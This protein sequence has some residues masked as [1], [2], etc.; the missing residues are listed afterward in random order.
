M[1]ARCALGARARKKPGMPIVSALMIVKCRGMKGKGRL[2]TPMTM[3][4]N[5]A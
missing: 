3:A 2:M 4:R 5:M 1:S